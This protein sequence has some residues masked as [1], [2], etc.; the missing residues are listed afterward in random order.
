MV[1]EGPV[2]FAIIQE[3]GRRHV[4][5][6]LV[7]GLHERFAEQDK[8]DLRLLVA[9]I[10]VYLQAVDE[11]ALARAEGVFVFPDGDGHGALVD[12]VELRIAVKMRIIA[13]GE[14]FFGVKVVGMVALRFELELQI[15]FIIHGTIVPRWAKENKGETRKKFIICTFFLQNMYTCGSYLLICALKGGGDCDIMRILGNVIS[16]INLKIF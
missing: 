5:V 3:N 10:A 13:V 15:F 9:E 14:V 7:E 2:G 8:A 6:G 1:E 16:D 12:A 11:Y 4:Q